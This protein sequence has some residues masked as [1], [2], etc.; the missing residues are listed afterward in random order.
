M[1][2]R[3]PIGCQACTWHPRGL[4]E[5]PYREFNVL[6]ESR[7]C[8]RRWSDS[9]QVSQSSLKSKQQGSSRRRPEQALLA[10][11]LKRPSK[12]HATSYPRSIA[13]D[14]ARATMSFAAPSAGYLC[15]A[16]VYCAPY[17]VSR[18]AQWLTRCQ[19]HRPHTIFDVQM[20]MGLVNVIFLGLD[21]NLM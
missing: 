2:R 4:S 5:R 18:H 7:A 16:R 20:A 19:S 13:L 15:Q 21:D 1:Y 12:G 6:L 10:V 17:A 9:V 14:H 11:V 3:T 8:S